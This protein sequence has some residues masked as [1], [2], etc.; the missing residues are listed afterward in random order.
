MVRK[1]WLQQQTKPLQPVTL[2]LALGTR[3][4]I[5]GVYAQLKKK[6]KILHLSSPAPSLHLCRN[7][8]HNR[9]SLLSRH[10]VTRVSLVFTPCV[11]ELAAGSL[12]EM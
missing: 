10:M 11:E 2:W 4:S 8:R 3:L 7:G 12:C 9:S 1:S 6:K 5:Y